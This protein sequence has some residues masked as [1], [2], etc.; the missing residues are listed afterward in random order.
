MRRFRFVLA[1]LVPFCLALAIPAAADDYRI[2]FIHRSV[3]GMWLLEGNLRPNL[4]GLGFTVHE[5][6]GEETAIPCD[7]ATCPFPTMNNQTDPCHWV[8]WFTNYMNGLRDWEC[9]PPEHNDIIMF[10][11]CY[12][13]SNI[14]GEGTEPGDPNDCEKTLWNY[15]AAFNTL[16]PI[17]EAAPDVL[18]IAVSTSP[19]SDRWCSYDSCSTPEEAT[20]ARTFNNWLKEEWLPAGVT[21]VVVFD[22]YDILTK[23]GASGNYLH[24]DYYWYPSPGAVDDHPNAQGLQAAT[25]EFLPFLLNAIDTWETGSPASV[26]H[27]E[28]M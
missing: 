1:G 12:P 21:N 26:A 15:K 22:F 7:T 17:F 2:N 19:R 25:A 4:E 18:F 24:P 5:A 6:H 16:L 8:R 10:K 11:S 13:A 23:H 14:I 3:G 20:R 27:W 28:D 9:T